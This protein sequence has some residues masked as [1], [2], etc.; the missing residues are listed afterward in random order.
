MKTWRGLAAPFWLGAAGVLVLDAI[1]GVQFLI[2]GEDDAKK[3][4]LVQDDEGRSRWRGVRGWMRGWV[5]SPSLSVTKSIDDDND[6]D[7]DAR[8][9]LDRRE[10]HSNY[11]AT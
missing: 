3:S 8:R 4:V 10:S 9:L 1:V 6:D 7:D 11:G 2:F 5:P